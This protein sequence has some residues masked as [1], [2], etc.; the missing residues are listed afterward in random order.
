MNSKIEQT[1]A[2]DSN[3]V[4][5]SMLHEVID[6]DRMERTFESNLSSADLF[7]IDCAILSSLRNT[8][9]FS[10]DLLR[11]LESG[12]FET[13]T[14]PPKAFEMD[15]QVQQEAMMDITLPLQDMFDDFTDIVVEAL[16]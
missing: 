2:I 11:Q 8:Q 10:R 3:Q 16:S 7:K 15:E 5:N 6:I 1:A 4:A 9:D 14:R 13:F 12:N